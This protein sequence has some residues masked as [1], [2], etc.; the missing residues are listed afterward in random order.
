M[1][2]FFLNTCPAPA[3]KNE[4]RYMTIT[5]MLVQSGLLTAL[6]MCVVFSFIIIL[7]ICMT[8]MKNIIHALKLDKEEPK[9]TPKASAPVSSGN[10]GAIIAAI[11]AAVHDKALKS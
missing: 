1:F 2:R 4:D 10:D 5:E 7:I 6:G 8:I 11:A 9:D 3:G